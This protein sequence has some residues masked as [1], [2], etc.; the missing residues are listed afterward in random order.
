[1]LTSR[2]L[3]PCTSGI[4]SL[5][6]MQDRFLLWIVPF[7]WTRHWFGLRI[8]CILDWTLLILTADCSVSLIWTHQFWLVT[9]AFEIG[10]HSGCNWWTGDAYP[11]SPPLGTWFTSS[12]PNLPDLYFI[13][14]LWD[15]SLFAVLPYY[16]DGKRWQLGLM[17][18][19]I[20]KL[21]IILNLKLWNFNQKGHAGQTSEYWIEISKDPKGYKIQIEKNSIPD[22]LN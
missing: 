16:Y 4:C 18:G 6:S 9:F 11:P 1:M 17:D 20:H 19:H 2:H 7:T 12:L 15:W 3:I 21:N 13:Q 5:G 8:L 10:A 14:G 22:F